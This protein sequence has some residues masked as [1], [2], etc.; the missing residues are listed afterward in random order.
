MRL[1]IGSDHAG[2]EAKQSLVAYLERLGYPI[3][4]AGCFSEESCD[5]PD[6]A[7]LVCDSVVNHDA[8]CGILICGTGIGMSI[9][10]NKITGIRAALC[11]DVD[12]ARLAREHNNANVLCLGARFQTDT[13]REKTT[14]I[15]LTTPF[16]GGRHTKRVEKIHDLTGR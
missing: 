8:E 2:F 14:E 7:M 15:F 1:A 12:Y 10:A 9:T 3:I 5:Y 6:Y 11:M 4:D 16:A 13:A